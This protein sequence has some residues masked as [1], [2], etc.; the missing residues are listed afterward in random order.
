MHRPTI[1]YTDGGERNG[2]LMKD[3][4]WKKKTLLY[5]ALIGMVFGLLSAYI[6]IRNAEENNT[7]VQFTSK[8]T[9]RIGSLIFR[10]INQFF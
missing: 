2:I 9:V 8:D 4:T 1:I 10:L 5:G 3:Q 7:S 6:R